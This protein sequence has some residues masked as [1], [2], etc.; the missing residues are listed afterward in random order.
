MWTSSFGAI[1]QK[2][3]KIRNRLPAEWVPSGDKLDAGHF[4]VFDH[5]QQV[6]EINIIGVKPVTST[7]CS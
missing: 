6:I 5:R 7:A 3:L 1:I 2:Q 4:A